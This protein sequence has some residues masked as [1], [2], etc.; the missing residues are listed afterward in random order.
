M[1]LERPAEATGAYLEAVRLSGGAAHLAL[2]AA[3]ALLA[4]GRLEEARSH[5][6]L[7]APVHPSA[8][9]LLAQIALAQ[10][11]LDEAE[12]QLD[13]VLAAG[14][15]RV[16]PYITHAELLLRRQRYSEAVAAT[17]TAE[18]NLE[19][20][21]ERF[22]RGLFLIRGD[23]LAALED[24]AAARQAYARE[25][26]IHPTGVTAYARLA[27]AQAVAGDG[28]GAGAT[29]RSLVETNPRPDAYAAAVTVL[30]RMGDEN[31]ATA[32]L[33]QA[34]ARWPEDPLLRS[35]AQG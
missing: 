31:A 10:G 4:V 32:V 8:H 18:E 5:A 16:G 15:R 28:P 27:F 9:D 7:A 11:D 17:R 22:L 25:I 20:G 33:R 13:A 35:L 34:L 23:A 1:A 29:L 3:S 24:L 2:P 19:D 12:R 26:R 6:E 21:P 30:R 14:G